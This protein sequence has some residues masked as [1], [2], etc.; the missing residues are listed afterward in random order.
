LRRALDTVFVLAKSGRNIKVYER[1]N[2]SRAW[3]NL[4][5]N[6]VER[7]LRSHL[8]NLFGRRHAAHWQVFG[9]RAF[10]DALRSRLR[11]GL[12][13]AGKPIQFRPPQTIVLGISVRSKIKARLRWG[14]VIRYGSRSRSAR[15]FGAARLGGGHHL[16]DDRASEYLESSLTGHLYAGRSFTVNAGR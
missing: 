4:A 15:F 8:L 12:A 13:R 2:L 6:N 16:A 9:V 5:G 11:L 7:G 3:F 10:S 1:K 14:N